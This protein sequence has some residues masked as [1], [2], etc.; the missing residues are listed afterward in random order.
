MQIARTYLIY[1]PW[2]PMWA[3]Y[4]QRQRLLKILRAYIR[5]KVGIDTY[6]TVLLLRF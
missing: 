6:P 2:R 1:I 4:L 5:L 3:Y